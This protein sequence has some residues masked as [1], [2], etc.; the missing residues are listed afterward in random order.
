MAPPCPTASVVLWQVFAN[1]E[2]WKS[3]GAQ[4]TVH[5]YAS[6]AS[7]LH[8]PTLDSHQLVSENVWR[9]RVSEDL[10]SFLM[11]IVTSVVVCTGTHTRKAPAAH[12]LVSVTTTPLSSVLIH[13][14]VLS[15]D[16]RPPL[17]ASAYCTHSS[18]PMSWPT[19]LAT[20]WL[21]MRSSSM[22][23]PRSTAAG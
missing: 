12:G 22:Y 18:T 16:S 14:S 19:T 17:S 21:P 4:P 5:L 11:S 6:T 9:F 13:V 2:I 3:S 10:P 8:R 1:P 15:R 23:T 7:E 20:F